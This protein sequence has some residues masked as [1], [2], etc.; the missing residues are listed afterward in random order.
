MEYPHSSI[1]NTS[2]KGPFSIAM[3]VYQSVD[4]EVLQPKIPKIS[5]DVPLAWVG[6]KTSMEHANMEDVWIDP[7]KSC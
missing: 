5:K 3:L 7:G 4:I 1:G 2:S 6:K